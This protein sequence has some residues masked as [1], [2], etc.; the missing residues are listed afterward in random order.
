VKFEDRLGAWLPV[1]PFNPEALALPTGGKSKPIPVIVEVDPGVVMAEVFV[2]VKVNVLVCELNSQT[3]VA[4]ENWPESTPVTVIVSAR[5][6]VL[7]AAKT[8]SA[9]IEKISL[10]NRDMDFLLV[11]PKDTSATEQGA[12]SPV[13]RE[14]ARSAGQSSSHLL[15]CVSGIIHIWRAA[16]NE[17]SDKLCHPPSDGKERLKD[18]GSPESWGLRESLRGCEDF[19]LANK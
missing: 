4:V 7:A 2:I 6:V 1:K 12:L 8:M 15:G 17:N 13:L 16:V 11:V 10:P 9:A 18:G 19:N 5:T 3:T 14:F